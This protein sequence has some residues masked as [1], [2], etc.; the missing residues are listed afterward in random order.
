MKNDGKWEKMYELAVEYSK[1]N[2]GLDIGAKEI[3]KG[4]R[5]GQWVNEQKNI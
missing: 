1:S 3:Y 5:L 4:E 2:G